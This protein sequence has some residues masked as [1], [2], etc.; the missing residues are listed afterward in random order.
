MPIGDNMHD[1]SKI[2][3]FIKSFLRLGL[4]RDCLDG[5]KKSLPECK[6]LVIDD[7][8]ESMSGVC[9]VRESPG[10]RTVFM[11]FDSGFGAKSNEMI[12]HLNTEYVLIGSDDFNFGEPGVREGIIQLLTVL[13]ERPAY[14]I[15][16]GRVNNNPYESCFELTA[17]DEIREL[18]GWAYES[19]CSGPDLKI[20]NYNP[21]DLT[22][23]FSLI[24]KSV[25]DSGNVHWDSDV[26]IGG[27]EHGA[28][29]I[30][31]YREFGPERVAY[32]PGVNINEL[33]HD[34]AKIDPRYASFRQRACEPGRI[35][36]KRRGIKRYGLADETWETS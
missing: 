33:P 35:C 8:S 29:F 16:S 34:H 11:P 7:S 14:M 4:L 6:V 36:L 17:P 32:V 26:K 19:S 2:T 20:V 22:V 3:I 30:D 12:H 21:C 23:N 13:E 9:S 25:F 18:N 15:A 28:F 24:R 10:M 5:I 31:V 1:L 27:G